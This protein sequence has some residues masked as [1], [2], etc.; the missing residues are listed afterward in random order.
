VVGLR[1][2]PVNALLYEWIRVHVLQRE[3]HPDI[4]VQLSHDAVEIKT[5][6][7]HGVSA[8]GEDAGA[9]PASFHL[10]HQALSILVPKLD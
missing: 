9:T 1:P 8:D 4:V 2:R 5:S 3:P 6:S 7:P 10:E